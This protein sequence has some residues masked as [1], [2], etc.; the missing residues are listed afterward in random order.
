MH[1]KVGGDLSVDRVQEGDEVVLVVAGAD[2]GDDRAPGDVEG[3]EEATV[4]LRS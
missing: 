1:V 2:V 3:G 4:P